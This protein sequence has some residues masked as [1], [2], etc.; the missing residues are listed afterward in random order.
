MIVNTRCFSHVNHRE[1][2]HLLYKKIIISLLTISFEEH[3]QGFGKD[4]KRKNKFKISHRCKPGCIMVYFGRS[5]QYKNFY[6]RDPEMAE[7]ILVASFCT[8]WGL[9]ALRT[10]QA[11]LETALNIVTPEQK[12]NQEQNGRKKIFTVFCFGDEFASV[13]ILATAYQSQ[14]VHI[15]EN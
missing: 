11:A 2:F 4:V 5:F 14:Q 10:P 7:N 13:H 12:K 8:F 3:S 1:N 9:T 15:F 6:L